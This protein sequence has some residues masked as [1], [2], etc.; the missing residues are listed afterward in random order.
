VRLAQRVERDE[1]TW[2]DHV[3]PDPRVEAGDPV[4]DAEAYAPALGKSDP[5]AMGRSC[6]TL[7]GAATLAGQAADVLRLAG[8]V[9]YDRMGRGRL[10]DED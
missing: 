7:D 9:V 3:S 5:A 1:S 8:R 6:V 4:I 10:V 2:H